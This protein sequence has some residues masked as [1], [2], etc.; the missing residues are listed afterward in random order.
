MLV[1]VSL[2]ATDVATGNPGG[3]FLQVPGVGKAQNPEY[4]YFR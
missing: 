1:L 2:G 4:V 3:G